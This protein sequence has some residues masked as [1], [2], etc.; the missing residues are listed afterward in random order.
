MFP[1]EMRNVVTRVFNKSEGELARERTEEIKRWIHTAAELPQAEVDLK[2]QMS[3]RRRE[4]LQGKKILLMKRLLQDAGHS[5]TDLMKNLIDRFDLTGILPESN[6][7]YK[8]I[9][10]ATKSCEELRQVADL[11]RDGMLQTIRSSGDVELDQQLH[12]AKMK[13]VAKGFFRGPVELADLPDEATLTR[14]FGVKQRNKTRPIDDYKASFVSSSVTQTISATVHTMDHIAAMVACILREVD[15]KAGCIKL[16]ARTWDLAHAYKQ[17]PLSDAAYEA[18][19]FLVVYSPASKGA[20]VFQHKV[21]PFGS[22]ASV[23]AFLRISHAL[24]KLGSR[25]LNLLWSSYF[26]DFFSITE[27]SMSK[28]T[29]LI[30]VSFFNILG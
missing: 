8:N 6:V 23:T 13:E 14:R 5:D 1:D 18:D 28:H 26:E 2:S 12:D 29:D 11:S 27:Q 17:V 21:L 3:S 10:L 20:E 7:F 9:R 15:S 16:T 25:L 19:S 22:V 30:I 24:W 4:V